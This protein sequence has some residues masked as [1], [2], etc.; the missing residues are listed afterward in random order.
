MINRSHWRRGSTW[1]VIAAAIFIYV[2]AIVLAG[3]AGFMDDDTIRYV[4]GWESPG[5][6]S[7]METFSWLGSTL[8]VVAISL[9]AIVLLAAVFGHRK[10]L[11]LF[12]IVVAGSAALNKLLKVTFQR[13]RPDIH[14]LVEQAGYS[15]PSGHSTAAFAL[16]GVLAYL[17]WR[18]IPSGWGRGL[19]IAIGLIMT[20]GIGIS[21]IYLGVHYPSDV[22]GGYLVS[23]ALLGVSA[24]VF[25]RTVRRRRS[26]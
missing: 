12:V 16:Y 23:G 5:L 14:R 1:A 25:E 24:E 21:R 18:H 15:F 19:M 13:D 9:V 3:K 20:L 7:M 2:S 17:L 26:A 22:I 6:T 11:I 4:Q 8:A 10:E